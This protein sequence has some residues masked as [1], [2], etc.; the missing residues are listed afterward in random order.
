MSEPVSATISEHFSSLKDPRIQLKT[1]HKLID[2]IVIT[3]CAVICGADDWQE[4]V[5]YGKAKHGWFK[6]FLELPHEI[7]SHAGIPVK[8]W[9]PPGL[10]HP[11]C[12]TAHPV[13]SKELLM[14]EGL[15]HWRQ[16]TTP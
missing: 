3:I 7:P 16:C 9:V 1:R 10:F 4:V 8:W 12:P 14:E 11:A 13:G 6:T 5:D 2:I 15:H